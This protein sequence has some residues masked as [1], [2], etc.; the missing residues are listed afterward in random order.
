MVSRVLPFV[1]LALAI[2]LFVGAPVLAE[3]TKDANSH[4]GTCVSFDGKKLVMKDKDGKEHTHAI[5][6]TTELMLD[7][8]KSDVSTFK[9]LK[10]GTKIRVWTD[11][12]DA[13]KVIKIEALDKNTDFGK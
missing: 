1:L 2:A 8:K 7:G 11:K 5:S 12:N 9:T 10:E 4:T 6:D 13:N 3:E